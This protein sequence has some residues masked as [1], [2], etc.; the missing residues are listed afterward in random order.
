MTQLFAVTRS[1][2]PRWNA[3]GGLEAQP[4]WRGHA[5]F[6]DALHAEGF[7]LLAGPLEGTSEALLI[8]RAASPAEI[9]ARLAGDPWNDGLLSTTRIAPWTLRLGAL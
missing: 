7:V 9:E 6:M 1:R 3:A 5:D 2:G 4:G 8:V